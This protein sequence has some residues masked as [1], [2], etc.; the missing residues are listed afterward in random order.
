MPTVTR[1]FSIT[2]AGVTIGGSSDYYLLHCDEAEAPMRLQITYP[3]LTLEAFVV[4]RS[5]T[6]S[7]FTTRA[8]ALETAFKTPAGDLSYTFGSS[9]TS[10]SQSSNTGMNAEPSIEKVGSIRFDSDR[11]RLYRIAVSITLP[12]NASGQNGLREGSI[13]VRT[14]ANGRKVVTISGAVTAL[15]SSSAYAQAATCVA[16]LVSSVTTALSIT[17]EAVEPRSIRYDDRNKVATFTHTLRELIFN[18][19]AGSLDNAAIKNQQLTATRDE[20][21]PGDQDGNGPPS[22]VSVAFSCAVDKTVT[23]DLVALWTGTIRPWLL[24]QARLIATSGSLA[25]T[26]ITPAYD[27]ANNAISARV[28][29][30]ATLGTTWGRRVTTRRS[31][32]TATRLVPVHNGNPA[33][34]VKQ[35]T[36]ET[37]RL[38]ITES[39]VRLTGSSGQG[40]GS[41]GGALGFFGANGGGS[42]ALGQL[43]G[44]SFGFFGAS[45]SGDQRGR[46]GQIS[47]GGALGGGASAPAT[48]A[49]AGITIPSGYELIDETEQSYP[50]TVGAPEQRYTI[51]VEERAQTYEYA[52]V[53]AA[54]GVGGAGGSG[55]PGFTVPR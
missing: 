35:Q 29:L 27:R 36:F 25:L 21:Y 24:A 30:L 49:I 2:Y 4:C 9:T 45:G 51:S 28:T 11:S 39:I 5:T 44:A 50:D 14:E 34:R 52:E 48:S 23:T 32:R 13:D 33:A 1:T 40:G 38:T 16:A 20:T 15:S 42:A 54:P 43:N 7:D 26:E 55:G 3:R 47:I 6:V 8:D 22:R 12:A 41:S 31:R 19:T 17:A 53:V 18:D 10:Y 46:L 37:K